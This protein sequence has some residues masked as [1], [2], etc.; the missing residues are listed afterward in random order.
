VTE[1]LLENAWVLLFTVPGVALVIKFAV[2]RSRRGS[3]SGP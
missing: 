3:D 1:L 2:E